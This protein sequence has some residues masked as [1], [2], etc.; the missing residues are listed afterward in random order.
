MGV[1]VVDFSKITTYPIKNRRNLVNLSQFAKLSDRSDFSNPALE[2]IADAIFKAQQNKSQIILMC[3]AH[4]VK[5]GQTPYIIEL[6]KKGL[7]THIAVNGAF[8]IHDFEIS[9]IGETS[10]DVAYGL[11]DGSFGMAQ[12]TGKLMN[13]A[14]KQYQDLGYGKAVGKKIAELNNP[15]KEYSVLW[16]AYN[17]NIPIT[18][19]VAVG[20]DIIHQHPSCDGSALGS[21]SYADFKL[22]TDSVSKLK[23]GVCLNI[24]SAVIMPEVFLKA[25]TIVQN[26]NCNITN[27]TTA[28]FDQINHYRPRVNVVQRPVQ[29]L[30]GESYII[31]AKHQESIPAL[32]QLIMEKFRSA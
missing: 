29:A 28:N 23:N 17:L 24:G 8:S 15:H 3:G 19:H 7:I 18:V 1:K 10:E 22:F 13:E 25:L 20:T 9:L 30:G 31:T 6:M 5:T 27:I 26:L 14:I 12:E 4:V 32:Y 11:K 16:N 21:A 2:N